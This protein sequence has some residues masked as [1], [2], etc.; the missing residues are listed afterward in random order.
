MDSVTVVA[1]DWFPVGRVLLT[2]V[3]QH[4]S[5]EQKEVPMSGFRSGERSRSRKS[6]A[7]TAAVAGFA[8]LAAFTAAAAPAEANFLKTLKYS[9][10]YPFVGAQ[11][12]SVD[13]DAAIPAT[14]PEKTLTEKFVIKA[15]ATAGGDTSIAVATVGATTVEGVTAA[16]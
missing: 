10:V 11:P 8:G 9:C 1:L 2:R 3:S 13:I 15:V 6:A 12:L 16:K 7:R 4:V 14:W 5:K